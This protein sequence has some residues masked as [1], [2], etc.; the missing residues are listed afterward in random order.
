MPSESMTEEA[1]PAQ[2][3]APPEPMTSADERGDSVRSFRTKRGR[4]LVDDTYL[5]V[6]ESFVGTYRNM[7]DYW[8]SGWVGRFVFLAAMFAPLYGLGTALWVTR[9]DPLGT[10]ALIFLSA[11]GVFVIISAFRRIV[12]GYTSASRIP[13]ADVRTVTSN[14]GTKGLTSPRLLVEYDADGATR[15]RVLMLPSLYT[16]DGEERFEEAQ[17]TLSAAGLDVK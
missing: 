9:E 16:S 17:R 15:K 14:R 4:C 11:I 7:Y 8:S 12:Q 10:P 2:Q 13:L 5:H 3:N 6:E 1:E